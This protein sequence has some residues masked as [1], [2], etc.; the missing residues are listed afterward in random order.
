MRYKTTAISV[1]VILSSLIVIPFAM[2]SSE[3]SPQPA[4]L[5]TIDHGRLLISTHRDISGEE[6][7]FSVGLTTG[8]V[9]CSELVTSG[10]TDT[11]PSIQSEIDMYLRL[12]SFVETQTA[13]GNL[14]AEVEP[15]KK[16]VEILREWSTQAMAINA[17][18]DSLTA[19]QKDDRVKELFRRN[20]IFW[21]K[22]ADDLV[23]RGLGQ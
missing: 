11:S 8:D 5:C 15:G 22:Y 4:N 10:G 1:I 16:A 18:W 2:A 12:L 3:R 20:A 6:T 13:R 17:S 21:D 14:S 7:A 23:T 9:Y 19:N